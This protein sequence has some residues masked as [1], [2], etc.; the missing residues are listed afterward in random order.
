MTEKF[1]VIGLNIINF[2]KFKGET[3]ERLE[4]LEK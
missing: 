3:S 4:K 2:L 1:E